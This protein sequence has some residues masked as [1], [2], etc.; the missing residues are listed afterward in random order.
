MNEH[1]TNDA[2]TRAPA[3]AGSAAARIDAVDRPY[4]P[5]WLDTL[6]DAI[7]RLPG[8]T[9][10]AYLVL[11]IP[12]VL[13]SST[14]LWLSGVRAWWD[15]EPTQAFWG[16][17]TIG[18]FAATHYLRY[19]AGSAFDAFRP[20]LGRGV[21]DPERSRYEF[22]VMPARPVLA[23]TAFSFALTPL[24][25]V[26]DPVAS[27][28]GE[29][30]GLGLVVRAVSESLTTAVVLALAYQALRQGRR[31]NQLHAIAEHVD[32]FR[33]MPLYAFSRLTAQ[34]ATVLIL[35]NGIG[36]VLNP[37]SLS[38]EASIALYVPWLVVFG[39]VAVGIFLVPLRGM[40]GRL[41]AVK[42][43]LE[44]AA[45]ERL[46]A[47]LGELNDAIDA[48]DTKAVEALDRTVGALRHE[49]E[50]LRTLPTW[51][52]ST[53]TIRGFA[54]ALFLPVVLFLIQRL[55]SQLLA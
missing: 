18:M 2:S 10:A 43:G 42:D 48:R 5:S 39:V 55:L 45:G 9:W 36:I 46:R 20:A 15:V 14:A 13:F 6:F 49:K 53:G 26:I 34:T 30:T 52:W 38:S 28:I 29:L 7:A 22:T 40:H 44:S 25:Y 3:P 47:L 27:Q 37:A 21:V 19:V 8:P 54:S 31:V 12:S 16:L 1:A 23:L 50:V 51:P 32:P 4:R 41:E 35:F 17:L 24:Y 33:P 11:A